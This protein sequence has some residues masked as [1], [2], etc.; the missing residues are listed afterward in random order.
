VGQ[1]TVSKSLACRTG[2][3]ACPEKLARYRVH[4]TNETRVGSELMAQSS[5]YVY[6]RILA[7]NQIEPLWPQVR[8]KLTLAKMNY[9]VHLITGGRSTQPRGQLWGLLHRVRL[10]GL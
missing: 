7:D 9:A 10:L 3:G 4:A 8:R 6:S 1:F 5:I 2:A